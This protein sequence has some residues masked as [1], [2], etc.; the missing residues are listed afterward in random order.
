[1]YGLVGTEVGPLLMT[2]GNILKEDYVKYD[3]IRTLIVRLN[4]GFITDV[5]Q[6]RKTLRWM[7]HE[8]LL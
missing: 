3:E 4:R 5:E 6:L 2:L 1:M 7:V 8:R